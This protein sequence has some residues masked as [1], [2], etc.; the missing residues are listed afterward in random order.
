M[1]DLPGA[2]LPLF[3]EVMN[4]V[5][6]HQNDLNGTYNKTFGKFITVFQVT[7]DEVAR[8]FVDYHTR[9]EELH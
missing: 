2:L 4:I 9:R 3:T 6:Q 1:D 7:L 5:N 8:E